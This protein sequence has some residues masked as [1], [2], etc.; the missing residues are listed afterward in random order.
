MPSVKCLLSLQNLAKIPYKTD[1]I[2]VGQV[3]FNQV[4]S[5]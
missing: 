2:S 1:Y 3:R 4:I 5:L